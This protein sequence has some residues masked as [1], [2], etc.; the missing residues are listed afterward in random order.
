MRGESGEKR[1]WVFG[2]TSN[3]AENFWQRGGAGV[4]LLETFAGHK[5]VP[6]PVPML[7]AS[8]A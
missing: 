7:V 6:V 1:E 2:A 3:K 8:G 4:H 5:S